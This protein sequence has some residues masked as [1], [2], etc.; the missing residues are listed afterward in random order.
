MLIFLVYVLPKQVQIDA[1]KLEECAQKNQTSM[2]IR[3][4]EN[5]VSH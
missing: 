1:H 3:G 4:R 5:R 2:S